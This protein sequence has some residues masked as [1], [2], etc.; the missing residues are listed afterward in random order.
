MLH[1]RLLAQH[2]GPCQHTEHGTYCLSLCVIALHAVAAT[3]LVYGLS[4]KA[5]G[6]TTT[7]VTTA[8][9]GGDAFALY[10]DAKSREVSAFMANGQSPARLTLEVSL[11]NLH[12]CDSEDGTFKQMI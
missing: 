2:V 8:G 4:I 11:I 5:S 6:V 9:I 12:Q 7:F 3:L 1:G 10:Y